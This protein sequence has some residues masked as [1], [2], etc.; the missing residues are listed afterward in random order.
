[1]VGST[2]RVGSFVSSEQGTAA[3]RT[4]AVEVEGGKPQIKTGNNNS[5]QGR[6]QRQTEGGRLRR[7]EGGTS[8]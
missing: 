7:F 5:A 3:R 8:Y 6:G 2:S 4:I 1:M